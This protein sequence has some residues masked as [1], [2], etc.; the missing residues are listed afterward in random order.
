MPHLVPGKKYMLHALM[1]GIKVWELEG[2]LKKMAK[3][4]P[5]GAIYARHLRMEG[6]DATTKRSRFLAAMDTVFGEVADK[7]YESNYLSMLAGYCDTCEELCPCCQS[8]GDDKDLFCSE[9][10]AHVYINGGA[11]SRERP[12]DEFTPT[13]FLN[14]DGVNI[15]KTCFNLGYSLGPVEAVPLHATELQTE[16]NEAAE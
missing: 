3:G 12:A 8:S 4:T 16:R 5:K 10:M 2:Y 7:K 15:E 6:L 11:L 9:L 1:T 14:S 13:D